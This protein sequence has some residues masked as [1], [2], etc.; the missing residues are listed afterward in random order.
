MFP[1]LAV[2]LMAGPVGL[3][4]I[5]SFVVLLVVLLAL[6]YVILNVVGTLFEIA[7]YGVAAIVLV[8]LLFFLVDFL[9]LNGA[10]AVGGQVIKSIVKLLLG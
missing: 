9:A 4:D 7:L 2:P 3:T 1:N 8:G 6:T 5:I 10:V